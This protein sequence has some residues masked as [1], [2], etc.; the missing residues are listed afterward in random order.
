MRFARQATV[1]S[2]G[3]CLAFAGT[4]L[5]ATSAAPKPKTLDLADPASDANAINA[6]GAATGCAGPACVDGTATPV[7][8]QD[9]KDIVKMSLASTFAKVGKT[10]VC[11]GFTITMTFTGAPDTTT[12]YR[13]LATSDIDTA[14]WWVQYNGTKT[15]LRYSNGTATTVD[16]AKPAVVKDKTITFTVTEADIK[17][18][19]ETLKSL[20]L[21]SIGAD[22]RTSVNSGTLTVPM[23]DQI[24]A[25]DGSY[26]PC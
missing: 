15:T 22:I 24:P 6:E 3:L 8:S 16:L 13:M 17:A 26:K 19:G 18:S 4:S 11:N 20:N 21:S 1:L 2:A 25:G 12:N 5:A 14:A 23:W 7:G 9:S 10:S